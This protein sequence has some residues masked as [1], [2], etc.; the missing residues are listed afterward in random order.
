MA[1]TC[2]MLGCRAVQTRRILLGRDGPEVVNLSV[3]TRET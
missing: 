3:L 1:K 2:G